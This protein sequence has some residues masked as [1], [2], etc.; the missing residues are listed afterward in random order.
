MKRLCTLSTSRSIAL[1]MPVWLA[2]IFVLVWRLPAL[3][4]VMSLV[5]GF[6]GVIGALAHDPAKTYG[7]FVFALVNFLSLVWL[8]RS[9]EEDQSEEIQTRHDRGM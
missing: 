5:Q 2:L 9:P 7:P 4:L 8:S 3:A 6:D 1:L